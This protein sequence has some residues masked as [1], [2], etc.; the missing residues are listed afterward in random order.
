MEEWSIP[1]MVSFSDMPIFTWKGC[2]YHA[3]QHPAQYIAHDKP[4]R[5]F[6]EL[7]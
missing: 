4:K 1:D 3:T 6:I 7:R 2:P 5:L